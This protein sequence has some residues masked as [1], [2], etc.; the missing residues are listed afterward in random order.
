MMDSGIATGADSLRKCREFGREE[1]GLT[2]RCWD[3]R[4]RPAASQPRAM[5]Q[6]P[7]DP[8][9]R[10]GCRS[11]VSVVTSDCV[12]RCPCRRTLVRRLVLQSPGQR[13]GVQY[14][15]QIQSRDFSNS[16]GF[17]WHGSMASYQKAADCRTRSSAITVLG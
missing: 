10:K 9:T 13:P 14:I 1:N 11:I 4:D 6:V 5:G 2:K 12:S 3:Q 15:R 8:A 16:W 7:T 17:V